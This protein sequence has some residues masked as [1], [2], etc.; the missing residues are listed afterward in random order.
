MIY[1]RIRWGLIGG[2]IS[3][4][5]AGYYFL[6]DNIVLTLGFL[7]AG[8]FLPFMDSISIFGSIFS[9]RKEFR[10]NSIYGS[11]LL[12]LRT[13]GMIAVIFLTQHIGWIIL[14]Y[15]LLN[16]LSR[17]ALLVILFVFYPPNTEKDPSSISYGKHLS[18]M[19]ILGAFAVQAD[20]IIMWHL[21]GPVALATYSFALSPIAQI[22]SWFKSIETLAFP[23]LA[24]SD[25]EVL[26][27]TLPRKIIRLFFF[28][29]PV[30]VLYI[31]LAPW[32]YKIFLPQYINSVLYSQALALILLFLPQKL[33]ASA[34]TAK[35]DKKALYIITT[36]TPIVRIAGISI[37][38]F[39][40]GIWGVVI[41][42]LLPYAVNT[43]MLTYFFLRMKTHS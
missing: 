17:L 21:L 15:F 9:G 42:T 23:K 43:F 31:T 3:L 11:S 18:L 4:G 35:A 24:S 16:T 32:L 1:A 14:A 12:I 6:Q 30:V 22:Q 34:I 41:G 20:K 39:F 8:I 10:L 38:V 29:V 28:V 26:K 5:F 7:I 25:S 19:N 33:L 2:F 37:F 36:A 13:M 27:K 40:F